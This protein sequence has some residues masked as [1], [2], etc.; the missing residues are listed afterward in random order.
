[1][2]YQLQELFVFIRN[3]ITIK[4]GESGGYPITRIE[5]I[6]HQN[7]NRE[8]L[9]YAGIYDLG[10]YEKYVLENEDILMS[11]INS[12]I[13]LGKSAI[14]EKLTD[15]TIIHGMNLLCLR[16]KKELIFPK[17]AYYLFQSIDFKK[18]INK[19]SKKSVNQA[20]FSVND[21][22]KL[23][24]N[25]PNIDIQIKIT[26]I[27]DES[28][29]LIK[30]CHSQIEALDKLMQSLFL[31]MFGN[32]VTNPKN[33]ERVRLGT[34]VEVI[35][36]YA[37]KSRDFVKEGIPIIK[38]GTAN[39]GYFDLN[40]LAYL[41]IGFE[42]IYKKYCVF[43]GDLL[44]TLTGTVGKEDYGNICEVSS[45]YSLYLLNQRVAKLDLK[46]GLSPAYLKFCFKQTRFK[47]QLTKLSRGVRQANISNDDIKNLIISVPAIEQQKEF[48]D[49]TQKVMHQM[50]LLKDILELMEVQ[51]KSLLYK[52]F[53][54]DLF[55]E[56]S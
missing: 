38:I 46:A 11:H 16:V 53:K 29:K 8:K 1:M 33:F 26:S 2:D 19:I 3:G 55:Q 12:E 15:E 49:V 41:P 44:I 54:G 5:T 21:L 47:G 27:L 22:K 4:Q 6:S 32:P 10:K 39:K 14:Y 9:G 36:G 20:S 25:I 13:H 34:L 50:I 56:P 30:N 48:E 18:S 43:P 24:V 40:N 7:V 35:G 23:R 52:A 51:Y 31:E 28:R 37:F 42:D 45:D 17:F